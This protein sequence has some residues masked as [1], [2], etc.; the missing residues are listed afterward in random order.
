[1]I[2]SPPSSQIQQTSFESSSN[3]GDLG[4]GWLIGFVFGD[5]IRD[6]V[7][8]RLGDGLW[9]IEG[10]GESIDWLTD[11]GG[12]RLVRSIVSSM[13]SGDFG[14]V[15]DWSIC[16]MID[17]L[18]EWCRDSVIGWLLV[19]LIAGFDIWLVMW[20]EGDCGGE[21]ET[22]FALLIDWLT[23]WV[24]DGLIRANANWIS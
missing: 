16:C 1:M 11:F 13:I 4:I 9:M 21:L 10:F 3:S 2:S 20:W 8:E 15:G 19:C 23:T 14:E 6:W 22:L 17:W 5:I 18:W 12:V 7:M 24:I